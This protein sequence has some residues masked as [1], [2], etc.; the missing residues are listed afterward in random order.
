MNRRLFYWPG[1]WLLPVAISHAGVVIGGTRFI[2]HAE[3]TTLS[4]PLRNTSDSDWLVDSHVLSGGRWPGADDLSPRKPP[5][6]VTPPLFLL[7]AGQENTL[8]VA[9]SGEA[10]ARDRESLFTLSIAAIPSGKTGANSVQ[11]AF[12]SA[13]KLIYRPVGLIGDPQQAYRHLVW[14]LTADGLTVR[15]PG[16]YYVTLFSTRVNGS[17]IDAAGVVAPFS[18][19]RTEWC[20]QTTRCAVRWQS[21]NDAGGVM[22]PVTATAQR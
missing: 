7:R 10:L 20:R 19:R 17:P 22:P 12:R 5:F 18:T 6:V 21:L 14:N 9:W 13:L 3:R 8:R 16:P 15:N 1:L 2:Y 4:V 11:M